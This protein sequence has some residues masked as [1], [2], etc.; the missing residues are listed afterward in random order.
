[1]SDRTQG[2]CIVCGEATTNRTESGGRKHWRCPLIELD[3]CADRREMGRRRPR[4]RPHDLDAAIAAVVTE[5]V[6]LHA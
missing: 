2:A 3:Q 5:E 4:N 1:M 6:H